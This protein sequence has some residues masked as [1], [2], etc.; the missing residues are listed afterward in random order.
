M[1]RGKDEQ[2]DLP[3]SRSL[4]A[5]GPAPGR[6]ARPVPGAGGSPCTGEGLR[7]CGS[8][9]SAYFGRHPRIT[10]PR[11]MGHEFA[12]VI[13]PKGERVPGGKTASGSAA[14]V[15][16]P[17]AS[18]TFAVRG[19]EIFAS[20]LKPRASIAT[21]PM[22]SWSG[23]P[24]A[25]CTSCPTT[26][27]STT[28]RL[29]QTL[30]VAYN[31]VKKRGEV[32]VQDRVFISGCGSI[33]LCALAV[34]KASGAKVFMV[35]TVDYRLEMARAM[36]AERVFNAAQENFVKSVLEAT[37]DKGVDKVIEA[38]GGSQD[39]TLGQASQIVKRAGLIVVI[40]TFSL[41][42]ATL[43]M[44]EFKDRELDLR[45]SRNYVNAFPDCLD[46]IAS[47]KVNLNR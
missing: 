47:G 24:S 2:K 17:A 42:K 15:T 26:S 5:G 16:S 20:A 28:R 1:E 25:I 27:P 38:V 23:S 32:Q 34:A 14:T 46:L 11:I 39:V 35:D 36:G 31:G 33:G 12:G 9:L 8:D 21:G 22:R 3:R 13:W 7:I 45:G 44:A 6:F 29:I 18:A 43:R 40:G 37:Q 4:W 10:F 41:N 19:A 30:A